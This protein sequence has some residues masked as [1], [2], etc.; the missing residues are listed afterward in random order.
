MQVCEFCAVG[1]KEKKINRKTPLSRNLKF[2]L[3]YIILQSF[4][5]MYVQ[6]TP[7]KLKSKSLDLET[8]LYNNIKSMSHSVIQ[9][10][11]ENKYTYNH[12][13]RENPAKITW[14]NNSILQTSQKTMQCIIRWSIINNKITFNF[15]YEWVKIYY[16][17][18]KF[19]NYVIW[20]FSLTFFGHYINYL[21]QLFQNVVENTF[22]GKIY[23]KRMI[24][25]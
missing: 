19:S 22:N 7:I 1:P 23:K 17:Y 18:K 5:S 2:T 16:I 24:K 14:W 4:K 8:P 25:Q 15:S 11:H 13:I 3:Y 12:R 9:L 10:L 21:L 6:F 20:N